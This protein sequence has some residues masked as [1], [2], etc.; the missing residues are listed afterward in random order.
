[1]AQIL[2]TGSVTAPSCEFTTSE[3]I[4]TGVINA[5]IK[6]YRR[7]RP[8]LSHDEALEQVRLFATRCANLNQPRQAAIDFDSIVAAVATAMAAP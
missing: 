1:M 5:C 4:E 2:P 6:I 3:I 8:H 7:W